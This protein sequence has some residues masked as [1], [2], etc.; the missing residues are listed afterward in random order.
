MGVFV[1]NKNKRIQ[2][3]NKIEPKLINTNPNGLNSDDLNVV[4]KKAIRVGLGV[5]TTPIKTEINIKNN[6]TQS[7]KP[8]DVISDKQNI[9]KDVI[10]SEKNEHKASEDMSF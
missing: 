4:D 5:K 10:C 3:S 6:T 8:F 2:N 7:V 1:R 9:L